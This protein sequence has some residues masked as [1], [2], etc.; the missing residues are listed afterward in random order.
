MN[1]IR[2]TFIVDP[3]NSK[4]FTKRFFG[5]EFKGGLSDDGD[6]NVIILF[7]NIPTLD[8]MTSVFPPFES[9]ILINGTMPHIIFVLRGSKPTTPQNLPFFKVAS[10]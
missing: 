4:K 7:C 9:E 2:A 1:D 5:A 3:Q 10:H 8:Y 6:E